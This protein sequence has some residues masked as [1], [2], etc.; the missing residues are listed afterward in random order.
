[1]TRA[2]FAV[3]PW[4]RTLFL[5][6]SEAYRRAPS[7]PPEAGRGEMAGGSIWPHS[8][9]KVTPFRPQSSPMAAPRA[10]GVHE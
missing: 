4:P 1:M 9:V 2:S 10:I 3:V 8:G 6:A 7:G 5:W